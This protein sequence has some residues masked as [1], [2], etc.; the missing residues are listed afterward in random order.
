M[1][2]RQL[3]YFVT[4]IEE[5]TITAAAKKLHISQ[6]PLS[7]QMRLLE[8]ELNV[9]LFERG[10]RQITL[11]DAGSLLYQYALEMLE[12]ETV[13]REEM[14]NLRTGKR[15][16]IRLGLIS[17]CDSKELYRGIEKFHKA[18]PNIP[19]KIYEGNTY[20]LLELLKN[21]K[22]EMAVI[23]TP[24]PN[25]DLEEVHLRTDT[26][27]AVGFPEFF[28]K[29]KKNTEISLKELESIPLILYRRWEPAIRS[30]FEEHGIEPDI[31]CIND[32][33]RTSLQWAQAGLGVAL[34]PSFVRGWN[35]GMEVRKVKGD[36]LKSNLALVRRKGIRLSESAAAFFRGFQEEHFL[37]SSRTEEKENEL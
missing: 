12:L 34:V 29:L 19:F 6:P 35:E 15:G 5:G 26:M 27:A 30:G 10:A 7:T 16:N 37:E 20:E 32:D 33:A 4:I 1:D 36:A 23:R 28:C 14:G 8:E 11:T 22:I 31:F 17:S 24:F 18:Y 2:I 3:R 25:Y 13:V 9:V 21:G